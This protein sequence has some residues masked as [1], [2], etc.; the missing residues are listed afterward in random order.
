MN[1]NGNEKVTDKNMIIGKTKFL[2]LFE[3]EPL[4]LECGRTLS[5]VTVAYQCYGKLNESCDNV[6]LICHALTGNAH[7]AGIQAELESDPVSE[8]DFL[9]S[10]TKMNLGKPGWW[11]GLIGPGKTFDTNRY[12]VV[13]PNILGSC[14]G[15]TGPSSI[16]PVTGKSYNKDFPTVTVR[17]M[18]RLQYEFLKAIGVK[19][20]AAISGGSLGGMQVFEWAVMYPDFVERIFP[21]A[22]SVYN[23]AWA[24]ALNVPARQAIMNDPVFN[25]GAYTEQPEKGLAV[26]RMLGMISYRS[27]VSYNRKFGRELSGAEDAGNMNNRFAIQSYLN[28]QGQKLVNRFDANT[29]LCVTNATDLHDLSRDRG[30]MEDVLGCIKAKTVCIGISSDVL[31]PAD[32][33]KQYASLIPGAEYAEIISEVGHDA[34]LI[35]FEQMYNIIT[36]YL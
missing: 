3:N 2:Q 10:Y 11:D 16:N 25:G 21:V 26:A 15:T 33:M 8:Y 20:I 18:V 36:P 6:I 17:D 14:Y 35:E 32:E 12:F 34:F 24:I 30:K 28:Y 4:Q 9:H 22:T 7:A 23:S 29:Y 19:K 27:N 5:P 31:Y 13:C 1:L